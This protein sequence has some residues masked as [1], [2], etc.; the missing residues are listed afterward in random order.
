MQRALGS[1]EDDEFRKNLHKISNRLVG[2]CGLICSTLSQDQ[3]E[4]KME[5]MKHPVP[6]R[7]GQIVN[8]TVVG[9]LHRLP[10]CPF[11]VHLDATLLSS[12]IKHRSKEKKERERGREQ[13]KKKKKKK[14]CRP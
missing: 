1:S 6:A 8:E 9:L 5:Q 13:K 11:I 2:F 10:S 7:T 14:E 12:S 4:E 3:V